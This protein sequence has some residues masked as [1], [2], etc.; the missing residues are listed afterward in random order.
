M[1]HILLGLTALALIV[2]ARV[3]RLELLRRLTGGLALLALALVAAGAVQL[4]DGSAEWRSWTLVALL[5]VLGSLVIRVA[6]LVVFEWLIGQ[7]AGVEVPRLAK[8]ILAVALHLALVTI[9][10]HTVQQIELGGLL[11]TSAVLTVVIGLALQE[12]LGTLLAGLALAWEKRLDTGTWVE[13]EGTV[14]RVEELGWRST[15]L[16]T[17][18]GERILVPNSTVARSTI[19][20]LGDGSR[21]VAVE[22]PVGVSYKVPPHEVKEILG[23]VARDL[24]SVLARPRPEILTRE[25]ADSAI[26]YDCR[27]WTSRPWSDSF[28]RDPFLT[29]AY[30]ALQR[31]GMEIPFPQRTLH[32]VPRAGAKD[33]SVARRVALEASPVFAGLEPDALET[34]SQRSKLLLFAPGEAVVSEGDA[35]RALYVLG[36]GSVVVEAHGRQVGELE[37]GNVFGEIAFLTGEPRSATVR[38]TT[39]LEVIEIDAEA[40]RAVLAEHAEAAQQLAERMARRMDRLEAAGA[41]PVT[42]RE[43]RGLVAT[44]REGLLRLVG[45]GRSVGNDPGG[46]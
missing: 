35:S 15:V 8:D 13:L 5:I 27:L 22:V 33:A 23:A 46:S 6:M 21:P 41:Q 11:A 25:F 18:L 4:A 44:L 1:T 10:L 19:R 40:L 32:I 16:R 30:V 39:A 24:P 20:L 2:L 26:V 9:V 3:S 43:R 12:T 42:P 36:S 14:G 7:R 17:V 45:G 31:A 34:L 29:R 37:A 38:A 28:V